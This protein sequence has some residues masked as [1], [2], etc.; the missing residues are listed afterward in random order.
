MYGPPEMNKLGAWGL[1]TTEDARIQNPA[2]PGWLIIAPWEQDYLIWSFHHLAELGYADAARPRDFLLR[3][4]VGTLTHRA[5]VVCAMDGGFPEAGA[6]LKQIEAMLPG[7]R[8]V[9]AREPYW[10]IAPREVLIPTA[11]HP[12]NKLGPRFAAWKRGRPLWMGH[13]APS[14]RLGN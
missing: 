11:N 8:Q 2:N 4:R 13:V 1:R 10:A 7:H 3:L 9:M 12:A 5:A 14:L 6:A